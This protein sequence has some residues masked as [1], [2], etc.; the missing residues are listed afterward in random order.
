MDTYATYKAAHDAA[1]AT[2]RTEA[3]G[4][5]ILFH[6]HGKAACT[7]EAWPI[8]L[9]VGHWMEPDGPDAMV[10]R[11]DPPCGPFRVTRD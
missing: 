1:I 2:L 11:F 4:Q 7:V 10:M 8:V 6:P 5:T 9:S 3:P